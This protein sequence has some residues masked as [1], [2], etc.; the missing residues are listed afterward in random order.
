MSVHAHILD[1]YRTG[2]LHMPRRVVD[3][4]L[5]SRTARSKL[6]ARG[7][8]Y[9]RSI[10][11]GL[12]LGYRRL[13]GGVGKWVVRL[14]QGDEAYTVE[15]VAT[16]DDMSDANGV[17]VLNFAQAQNKAR[18]LRDERSKAIAG[19]GP[20]TVSKAL[21]DYFAFLR[22]EGRPDHLVDDARRRATSLIEHKLGHVELAALN[23]NQ[24]D[25]KSTRLNSSHVANSYAVF[26]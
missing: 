9:Y 12:H 24:L 13:A 23:T 17:D 14:Y 16:A 8:P 6:P 21:A 22:S 3:S 2:G 19:V 4:R 25:R 10:D 20:Y 18:A 11:P 7:K 5:D 1:K 26:C 15:T